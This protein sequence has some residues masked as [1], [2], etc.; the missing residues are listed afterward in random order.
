MS[1]KVHSGI[2]FFFF[3]LKKSELGKSNRSG[4]AQT[5]PEPLSPLPVSA[6]SPKAARSSSLCYQLSLQERGKT[7]C[8]P[9][10]EA[11]ANDRRYSNR[12]LCIP[13]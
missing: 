5:S 13:G 10:L 7:M 9:N 6:L 1:Q 8:L 4:A 2:F 11:H 3:P 12:W